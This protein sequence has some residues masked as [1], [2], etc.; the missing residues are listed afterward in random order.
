MS[1]LLRVTAEQQNQCES[2]T[3]QHIQLAAALLKTK[4]KVAA[5]NLTLL[6]Q[7]LVVLSY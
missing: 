4:Q 7:I 1:V 2:G 5:C 3:D 6:K